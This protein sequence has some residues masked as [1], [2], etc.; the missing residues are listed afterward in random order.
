MVGGEMPVVQQ[1][2]ISP[3]QW[4]R[5]LPI[6]PADVGADVGASALRGQPEA[7]WQTR[8]ERVVWAAR[9]QCHA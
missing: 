1:V 3:R 9:R 4:R 2:D 6:A 8:A 7:R 5:R